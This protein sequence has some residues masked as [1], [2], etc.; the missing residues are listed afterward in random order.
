VLTE[1]YVTEDGSRWICPEC[2]R[3]LQEE[4]GWK[5]AKRLV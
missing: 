5:L 1:G 3:D 2:F 4:M